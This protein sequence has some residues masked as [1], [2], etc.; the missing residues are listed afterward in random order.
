MI[1]NKKDTEWAILQNKSLSI[2]DPFGLYPNNIF[3]IYKSH[4]IFSDKLLLLFF[5]ILRK[6]RFIKDLPNSLEYDRNWQKRIRRINNWILF[7]D[8]NSKSLCLYI[9]KK[10]PKACVYTY[11]WDII[12]LPGWGGRIYRKF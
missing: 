4:K 11:S 10:N 7:Y 6:L 5:R 9:K 8:D 1:M 2:I 12:G 3:E